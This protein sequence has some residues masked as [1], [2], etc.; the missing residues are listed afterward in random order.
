MTKLFLIFILYLPGGNLIRVRRGWLLVRNG[1]A[2]P[3]R[4]LKPFPTVL[5]LPG[6]YFQR[7]QPVLVKIISVLF[8]HG[9][10][11][12]GV[13]LP[14]AAKINALIH[15]ADAVFAGE[16]Q[17]HG[18]VLAVAHIGKADP[19]QNSGVK[20]PRR[21]D[22]AHAQKI[23]VAVSHGPFPVI[24]EPR[25]NLFP[26]LVH[27][28]IGA[29]GHCARPPAQGVNHGLECAG[30]FVKI[31]GIELNGVAAAVRR[32][33]RLVPASAD[34]QIA[35]ERHKMMNMGITRGKVFQKL[36]RAVRGE[37]VHRQNIEGKVRF[38]R[39]RAFDRVGNGFPAIAYG[40]DDAGLPENLFRLP[41]RGGS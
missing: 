34:A 26:A 40:D 23:V 24:D 31:V 2:A 12:V 19:A 1:L 41:V 28:R 29:H 35:A 27:Q 25:R 6:F 13:V 38:L 39:Q 22:A 4:S 8:V 10:L 9:K 11:R 21:A 14:A 15:P 32:K 30:R 3:R 37:V 36:R 33:N 5:L 18:I 20:S 16:F 17:R 7:S